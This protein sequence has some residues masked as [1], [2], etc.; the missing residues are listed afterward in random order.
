MR[1][2]KSVRK[3]TLVVSLLVGLAAWPHPAWAL[4]EGTTPAPFEAYQVF[5]DGLAIG[6]TLMSNPLPNLNINTVLLPQSSANLTG[7]PADAD[8]QAVFLWWSG[9]LAPGQG[10][11]SIDR[12]ALLTLAS[13][14]TQNVM[15]DDCRMITT[16]PGAPLSFYYC[17]ADVT[18]FVSANPGMFSWNGGYT[19]ADVYADPGHVIAGMPGNCTFTDPH[20]QAKYA[21]WSLIFVYDSPAAILQRDVIIYDGFVHMDEVLLRGH[22]WLPLD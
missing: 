1:G 8:P 18:A 12:D 15:A 19:V 4:V 10:M 17:R 3:T 13:G 22:D 20:C 16:F 14:A 11:A 6:N 21:G 2:R 9:S 7:V 5:G